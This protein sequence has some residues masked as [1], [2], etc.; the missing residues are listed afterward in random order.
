M[1]IYFTKPVIA[2]ELVQAVES[3]VEQKGLC[4]AG[5]EKGSAA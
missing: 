5:P 3:L 4:E 1:D 2:G